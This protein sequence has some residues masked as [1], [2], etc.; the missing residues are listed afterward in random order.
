MPCYSPLKGYKSR[1]NG[2]LVFRAEQGHEKMEVACGSCLGCRLDRSRTWATR[3]MHEAQL[4][5]DNCFISLTYSDEH[6]PWDGGLV[7]EHFQKFMKRLRKEFAPRTIRYYHCGEYGEKLQRP[8]YH[9]CLFNLDF[10]DKKPFQQR[11]G[12]TL[13]VSETL[14]RIW[15]LGFATI[16]SLTYESAAYCARYVTKKVTGHQAHTHYQRIILETGEVVQVPAE[17]CTMSRRPGIARNWY[18]KYKE[19]CF[20]SDQ[21]PIPGIGV[22]KK[23]PRYYETIFQSEDPVTHEEIKNLRKSFRDAHKEEYTPSRLM[24]KYKVKKAQV[25]MLKRGL[26][27]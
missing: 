3:I 12:Y 27:Q 13:Y 6:L 25:E 26:E 5:D 9:A 23:A 19:D 24:Q 20:P 18:E 16:G 22:I 10:F 2:G 15:G 7:K 8:H 11:N 17:Y 1:E 21:V 4:H 14:D